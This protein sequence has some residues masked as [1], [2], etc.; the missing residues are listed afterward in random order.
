MDK[1]IADMTP[2]EMETRLM[3]LQEAKIFKDDTKPKAKGKI[4]KSKLADAFAELKR[5]RDNPELLES[6]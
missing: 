1:N 3:E 6:E 5:L 4:S 2:E